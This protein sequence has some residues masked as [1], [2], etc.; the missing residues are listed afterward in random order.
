MNPAGLNIFK[1]NKDVYLN[2]IASYT[3]H[4]LQGRGQKQVWTVITKL[5][6]SKFDL[7]NNSTSN[8]ERICSVH[9]KCVL[10]LYYVVMT[11]RQVF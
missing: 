2:T 4:L 10:E 1:Y 9:S 11:F 7:N 8:V 3:Y 6:L 5:Y